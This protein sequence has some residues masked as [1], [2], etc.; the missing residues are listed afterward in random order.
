MVMRR[1]GETERK[2]YIVR[3]EKQEGRGREEEEGKCKR[4]EEGE[5]EEVRDKETMKFVVVGF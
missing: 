3:E 1:E 5:R 2:N 4:K